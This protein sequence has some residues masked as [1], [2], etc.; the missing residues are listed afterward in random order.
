M[1]KIITSIIAAALIAVA[2]ITVTSCSQW[3]TPFGELDDD[4]KTV[5]VKY[6]ANGGLFANTGGVTVVDAYDED[7]ATSGDGIKIVAPDDAQRGNRAFSITK[8]GHVFAGWYVAE[9]DGDGNPIVNGDGSIRF[10]KTQKWDFE[11]DRLKLD[12]GGDYTSEIP[13][14]TLCAAWIPYTAFN[15]Y[16]PDGEGGFE[17]YNTVSVQKLNHPV[18]TEKGN[19]DMKNY[20]KLD[21]MTFVKAYSDETCTNEIT[22][23]LESLFD[24]ENVECLNPTV[25]VY[26]TWREGVWYR[27]ETATQ[28]MQNASKRGC[29]EILADIDFEGKAWPAFSSFEGKFIG[30]GH[31]ISNISVVQTNARAS[32]V[33]L[34]EVIGDGA[35]FDSIAFENVKYTV[36]GTLKSTDGN[37]YGTLA[38][39]IDSGAVFTDVTVSGE[40]ILDKSLFSDDFKASLEYYEIGLVAGRGSAEGIDGTISLTIDPDAPADATASVMPDGSVS[41]T[42]EGGANG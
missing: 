39:E 19:L 31:K 13:S 7:D 4:G 10:D 26:T 9:L 14:L 6:L 38:G 20:P 8:N 28:L 15:I 17:L 33:G 2:V 36:I 11:S 29:Y 32:R 34:F 40:L 30:N 16:I 41:F 42:D 21:G 23:N 22:G 12:A 35:V 25:N 1:K 27:I 18:W 3:Q 37:C 5:S 24:Y